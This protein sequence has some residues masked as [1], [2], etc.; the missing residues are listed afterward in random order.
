MARSA[1]SGPPLQIAEQL[2]A[3]I[4]DEQGI[5]CS[6][7]VAASI[8]VAKLASRRAKPDGV[9]VVPPEGITSF[10]HPLDVG[11]LYGVGEKTQAM[12][13]RLGLIT[14]GDVAHTPLR[15]LQRAVGDGLG[16][17]LHELAWG[18]DRREVSPG[19]VNVFG[20]GGDPD[21]SMGAQ[22]TFGRDID[23][24]EVILREL[25]TLTAKV[26]GR[27]RVA[28]VAGRTVSITVRFADFTTITRSRTIP[29]ATDVTQEIYRAAVRLYDALGLQR[30][31]L[32]LVGVRVEGLVPR[33]AVHRQGVLGERE[34]G[35]PDADRAVDR[36]ARRFGNAAVRPASLLDREERHRLTTSPCPAHYPAV[37]AITHGY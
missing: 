23:D 16:S 35:W 7:G 37:G 22:E 31:R 34:H 27:M 19:R 15:T 21:K 11:E 17:Q 6:V 1:G 29:E 20:H 2:R 26:A 12:L 33:T 28:G 36:A 9:V 24:R 8:S 32:R 25:L 3:T 13:H 30:A 4:H 5:N 18:S 10:L 14:V